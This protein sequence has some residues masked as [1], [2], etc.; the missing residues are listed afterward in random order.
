[1]YVA[2]WTDSLV[3]TFKENQ[4][5]N[6]GDIH[7]I[8]STVIL[9]YSSAVECKFSKNKVVEAVVKCVGVRGSKLHFP[10]NDLKV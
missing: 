6:I 7:E 3:T 10:V 4:Q 5:H 2:L 9:Q 1:M 8:P